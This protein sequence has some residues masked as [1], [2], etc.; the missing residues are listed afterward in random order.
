MKT[1]SNVKA[2]IIDGFFTLRPELVGL[3]MPTGFNPRSSR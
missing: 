2:G 3:P 1:K